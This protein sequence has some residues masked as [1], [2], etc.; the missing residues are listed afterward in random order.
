MTRK[1]IVFAILL[2]LFILLSGAAGA[3][4][5]GLATPT[6]LACA[7]EKTKTTIYFFESPAYT[8]VNK[9]THR[10]SGPGDIETVCLDCGETLSY[11][12]V[13]N[14][15]EIRPHSMKKGKCVLCGFRDN[16][17]AAKTAPA[18]VSGER[19]V[20]AREEGN[21]KGLLTL[22]MTNE[23]LYELTGE[24]VYT[25]LVQGK[26]GNAAVALN[27]TEMLGQ[28][29]NTG[30]DLKLELAEQ[31]DDSIFASLYLV[32]DSGSRSQPG[33]A[34]ITLR[35]YRQTKSNVRVSLAPAGEDSLIET[36][37]VWN[38]KGYWSVPYLQ[39]GT[40]FLLQ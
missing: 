10:V 27:V 12:T 21:T 25:V 1:S 7:H 39:E 26:T 5:P 35:F 18:S 38:E 30:A 13:E 20:V 15:E 36:E 24:N 3:E 28:T 29:E 34:G 22:T 9:E 11:E 8:S 4:E 6:D 37:A 31:E 17:G 16:A 40:Y 32:S 23:D 14:A 33:N 19:K 2:L